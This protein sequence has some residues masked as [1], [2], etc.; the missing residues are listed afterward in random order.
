MLIWLLHR[1]FCFFHLF[2]V[3]L[4]NNRSSSCTSI[5]MHGLI[6]AFSLKLPS[7]ENKNS[8]T[9]FDFAPT[10][11]T[12]CCHLGKLFLDN[13]W[14]EKDW[15]NGWSNSMSIDTDIPLQSFRWLQ[16]L[17]YLLYHLSIDHNTEICLEKLNPTELP[18]LCVKKWYSTQKEPKSFQK[19]LCWILL[20]INFRIFIAFQEF[21][22]KLLS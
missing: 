3:I 16:Y 1:R 4:S 2:F 7:T 12:K 8:C 18:N 9:V 20:Q 14:Q 6:I 15:N 11:E 22:C 10:K 17:L 5:Y 13:F 21:S 19:L